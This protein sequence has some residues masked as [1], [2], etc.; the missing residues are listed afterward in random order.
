MI[1]HEIAG[2]PDLKLIET[3]GLLRL[4]K[5]LKLCIKEIEGNG[6]CLYSSLSHQINYLG[7]Q[8][9]NLPVPVDYLS[10]RKMAAEFMRSNA[11]NYIFF[12]TTSDGDLLDNIGYLEYCRKLEF[13]AEWGGQVEIKAISDA[14]NIQINVL[15]VGTGLLEIGKEYTSKQPLFVSYHRV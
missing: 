3:N 8:F 1:Q 5:P 14:L 2:L 13:E 4:M 7:I 12:L 11:D 9:P 10:L 15:Q 6:H